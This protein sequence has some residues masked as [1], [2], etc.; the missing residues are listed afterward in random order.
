M[1]VKAKVYK[2]KFVKINMKVMF[3]GLQSKGKDVWL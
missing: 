1:Y 2:D 3:C